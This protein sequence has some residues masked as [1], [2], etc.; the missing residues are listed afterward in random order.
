MASLP[1]PRTT[2]Q[3]YLQMEEQS[4]VLHEFLNGEVFE[5]ESATFRHQQIGSQLIGALRPGLNSH[6]CEIHFHGTRVATSKDGLYTY[7][8]LVI[9]CGQPKFWD[10]DPD[11]LCNPKALI[12]ILSPRTKDYDRGTKFKLYRGLASLEEYLNIHQDAPCVEHHTRQ[13]DGSW[14]TRDLNGIDAVLHLASAPID[15]PFSALYAGIQFDP[16]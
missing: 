9:M 7:P 10:S 12:E 13:P 16:A 5:M 14:V 15:I 1:L 4:E 3:Q 8:D 11:T 2:L 6:G